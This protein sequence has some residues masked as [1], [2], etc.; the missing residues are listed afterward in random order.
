LINPFHV[1]QKDDTATHIF[2]IGNLGSSL[3][4]YSKETVIPGNGMIYWRQKYKGKTVVLWGQPPRL[5]E[6]ETDL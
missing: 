2:F 4:S 6:K 1:I 5:S 3:I